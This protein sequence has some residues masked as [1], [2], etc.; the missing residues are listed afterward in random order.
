[1]VRSHSGFEDLAARGVRLAGTAISLNFLASRRLALGHSD[2]HFV[3]TLDLRWAFV[4]LDEM[5][6]QT[7]QGVDL[8]S[9]MGNT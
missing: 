8:A 4:R 2:L 3:E 9:R 5:F 7:H 1:M 6:H